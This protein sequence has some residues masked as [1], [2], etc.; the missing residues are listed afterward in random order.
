MAEALLESSAFAWVPRF[1]TLA[2]LVQP[3]GEIYGSRA[4]AR[5]PRHSF[6]GRRAYPREGSAEK[7]L[8]QRVGCRKL[9]HLGGPCAASP[10][11]RH[12]FG[13][14]MHRRRVPDGAAATVAGEARSLPAL[15]SCCAGCAAHHT[16]PHAAENPSQSTSGDGA[17]PATEGCQIDCSAKAGLR[18]PKV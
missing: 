7:P 8:G 5:G 16:A 10:R 14:S 18:G 1:A 4:Q 11:V 3:V 15:R 6:P 12:K 13:D 2:L 17:A 9:Y